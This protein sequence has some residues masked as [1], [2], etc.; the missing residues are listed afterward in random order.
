M[1]TTTRSAERALAESEWLYRHVTG[2]TRAIAWKFDR[3]MMT[4]TYVSADAE[5]IL[6]FPVSMWKEPSILVRPP[7]P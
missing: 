1:F 7:A 4:F 3:R 6:G 5:A 2:A